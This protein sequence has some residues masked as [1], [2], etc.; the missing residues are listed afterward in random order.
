M[1]TLQA[2]LGTIG[3]SANY[4][5]QLVS[6]AAKGCYGVAGMATSSQTDTLKT[7]IFGRETPNQGVRVT[8]SNAALTIQLHIKV[9]YGLNIATVVKSITH[10]VRH[11]VEK[12][13]G[14]TVARIEVSV[15]DIVFES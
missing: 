8:Q 14:L 3:M 2:P 7:K 12:A 5:A 1:I 13:T 10:R 6:A 9:G 15:D 11:E 4:F